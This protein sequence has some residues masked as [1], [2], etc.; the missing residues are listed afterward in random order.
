MVLFCKENGHLSQDL[1]DVEGKWAR[2]KLS[3]DV[4]RVDLP[5]NLSQYRTNE[6]ISLSQNGSG[7]V[8]QRDLR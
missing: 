8:N 7:V 1:Q 6:E 2:N 4:N 3:Q 5:P